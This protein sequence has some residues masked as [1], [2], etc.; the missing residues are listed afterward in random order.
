M[1]YLPD[2]HTP[3]ETLVWMKDVVFCNEQVIVGEVEGTVVGYAS[4]VCKSLSNMY[5]LP[6]HQ[7][8]GVGSKLLDAVLRQIP[9]GVELR[10][11][12][13]NVDAIRFYERNGF[14]TISGTSGDNEER[15]PDRLMK[16]IA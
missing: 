11:F 1:S 8:R 16:R 12:E 2:L 5:V 7:R 4:Y 9:T 14:T 3:E 13:D 15:L 10:V 6:D